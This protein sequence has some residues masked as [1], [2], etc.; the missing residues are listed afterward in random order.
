MP[1]P[2]FDASNALTFDLEH[3]IVRLDGVPERVLVPA[4]SL[5]ALVAAAGELATSVFGAAMGSDMGRRV[6]SRLAGADGVRSATI[7]SV[8]DHLGGELALAGLGTLGAERW[9]SA[10]VIVIDQSP[11]AE[12][13]D[14]LLA[15]VL[16]GAFAVSAGR[17]V[18]AAK[19]MRDGVRARFLL[20]SAEG[21]A[22]VGTWI[23]AG[24]DWGDALVRLHGRGDT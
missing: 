3:G 11:L 20:T 12:A 4:E 17:R 19:L 23:A 6:A 13:G 14:G 10:L 16:E 1:E 18:S 15:A 2:H 5:A 7:D 8:V 9:G 22:K 24:S 21:A